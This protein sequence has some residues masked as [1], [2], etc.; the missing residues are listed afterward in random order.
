MNASLV[1]T[2]L[3]STQET[4]LWSC[5]LFCYFFFLKPTKRK[6]LDRRK[7]FPRDGRKACSNDSGSVFQK[8]LAPIP[9]LAGCI[10]PVATALNAT[11]S[12]LPRF[13]H[14]RESTMASVPKLFPSESCQEPTSQWSKKSLAVRHDFH[15]NLE[16]VGVCERTNKT[17]LSP[18]AGDEV[19]KLAGDPSRRQS[20]KRTLPPVSAPHTKAP[21]GRVTHQPSDD[22]PTCTVPSVASFRRRNSSP[23]APFLCDSADASPVGLH[24]HDT[25]EQHQL[26]DA[27][28]DAAAVPRKLPTLPS[29][30]GTHICPALV[31]A[32]PRQTVRED[33]DCGAPH[34]DDVLDWSERPTIHS[35]RGENNS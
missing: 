21:E 22:L 8:R 9:S 25:T 7:S 11:S 5:S 28:L 23:L 27:V 33:G 24:H 19:M 15:L 6:M 29:C 16:L 4:F 1:V 20:L 18:F 17:I 26:L 3:L 10:L 32:S 35:L 14:L 12:C 30:G 31:G 2:L 34:I 13:R